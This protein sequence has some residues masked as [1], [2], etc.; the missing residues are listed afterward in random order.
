[1]RFFMT[2][3]AFSR[4]V[5]G[6]VVAAATIM[7]CSAMCQDFPYLVPEAPEFDSRGNLMRSA[8]APIPQQQEV[9]PSVRTEPPR[10]APTFA[11]PPKTQLPDEKHRQR[12]E[13]PEAPRTPYSYGSTREAA[14]AG[15]APAPRHIPPRVAQPN[16]SPVPYQQGAM[17]PPD[18]RQA[19]IPE[20]P[21][22]SEYPARIAYARSEGEMQTV[23]RY[24]L[25]CLMQ[26]GW[27][28]ETAKRHVTSV[29]DSWYRTAR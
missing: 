22:C 9:E 19:A 2:L 14:P 10:A 4:G 3:N 8:P 29:V 27:D 11:N 12:A 18:P 21:D 20:R 6:G 28:Q 5:I 26:T 15:V 17:A 16:P 1:M 13:R 23:A 25:G 24:Y 7:V